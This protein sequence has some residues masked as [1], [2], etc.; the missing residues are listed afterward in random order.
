MKPCTAKHTYMELNRHKP[1]D[2]GC[3]LD[4]RSYLIRYHGCRRI[5]E[6]YDIHDELTSL[7]KVFP[8]ICKEADSGMDEGALRSTYQAALQYLFDYI[9]N[10][11]K[12]VDFN[13][14]SPQAIADAFIE[15]C[16]KDHPDADKLRQLLDLGAPIQA[17]AEGQ[18][19]P[20][21]VRILNS[22]NLPLVRLFLERGADINYL[23]PAN[24][25]QVGDFYQTLWLSDV[26][27]AS[28]DKI[29]LML[30]FGARVLDKDG[31]A[32]TVLHLIAL[33]RVNMDVL[34]LFV[35]L[36]VDI[37][38]L[39]AQHETALIRMAKNELNAP[40][41]RYLLDLG[42]D[43]NASPDGHYTALHSLAAWYSDDNHLIPDLPKY[44]ADL[45]RRSA[46]GRTPLFIAAERN[47]PNI[48]QALLAIGADPAIANQKGQTP[49]SFAIEQGYLDIAK[50][51]NANAIADYQN[52]P[53][54]V[55]M[56]A[57]KQQIIAALRSG[58]RFSGS[59]KES[60]QEFGYKDGI[61]QH[62]A[63]DH[64]S[65]HV[66]STTYTSDEAALKFL[67]GQA[68][69]WDKQGNTELGIWKSLL[70]RLF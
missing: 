31:N 42:A 14:L 28:L 43:I 66:Y 20:C 10:Y 33:G 16:Y 65:D 13:T 2:E 53:E 25:K 39:N 64:F 54:Y 62:N 18:E 69:Y 59:D 27:Y 21:Y 67:W 63:G 6:A 19:I 68:G 58:K 34:K 36:G 56:E 51:L 37:H 46:D 47:R 24:P 26:C 15:E 32:N 17:R 30:E 45:N 12:V 52:R 29:K 8:L 4:P 9:R 50:L 3:V 49:Y 41:M 70:A 61:Y 57:V 11:G 22:D 5:L 1:E 60:W 44:G 38:A 55:E 7:H 23:F 48:V 35:D 40:A